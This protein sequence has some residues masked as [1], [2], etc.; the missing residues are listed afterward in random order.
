VHE[1]EALVDPRE[2]QD[3]VMRSSMLIF[4]P[5]TSR[6]FRHVRASRAPPKAGPSTR[7]RD[8]LERAVLISCPD[9]AATPVIHRDAPD[10]VAALERLEHHVD[11]A[12]HSTL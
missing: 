3:V 1:V 2:R 7:A 6:R 9:K 5:C 11:V 10:E 12:E 8:E 4:F